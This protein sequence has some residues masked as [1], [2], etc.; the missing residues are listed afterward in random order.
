MR[1]LY[2]L[3]I[4]LFLPIEG[5]GQKSIE[6]YSIFGDK[7]NIYKSIDDILEL[8]HLQNK[9]VYA[10]I[11]G[12]HCGPCIRE[13]SNLPEL[14][15]RFNNDSV[16]FL[17]LCIPYTKKWNKKNAKLWEEL[18]VKHDLTGINILISAECY[19]GGFYEKYKDK[20][21]PEDLYT[22]PRYLLVNKTG[23][24]VDF[25]A[26]RPSS[27]EELFSAIQVLLDENCP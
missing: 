27:K 17:Y 22:I 18:I 6:D 12:T 19:V 2:L 4:A 5:I 25:K 23:E 16:A 13:F 7:E 15:T 3:L 9:V 10:D 8:D 20:F 1:L 21:T 24:I 26:P 14:K 11:W